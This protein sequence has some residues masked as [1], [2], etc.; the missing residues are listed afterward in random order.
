MPAITQLT[1]NFLGGVSKQIDEKKLQGQVTEC[2]NGYPDPT[3]GL[4]KR[5]GMK[6]ISVLKDVNGA[7]INKATLADASWF[8]IDRSEAGSY[9]GCIKNSNIYVWDENGTP[10]TI[11]N[12]AG[13]YL[14]DFDATTETAPSFHFRSIQDTTIITNK[15]VNTAMQSNAD[16][17]PKVKATIKLSA[18]TNSEYFVTI[19]G[20]SSVS[21]PAGTSS[22]TPPDG[23][24]F[25][26]MLTPTLPGTG[27]QAHTGTY[28]THPDEYLGDFIYELIS[29]Q[30]QAAATVPTTF[31]GK[32]YI[33]SHLNSLTIQRTDEAT[34]VVINSSTAPSGNFLDFDISVKGGTLNTDIEVYQDD[35]TSIDKLALNSF[36]GDVVRVLNTDKPEDDYY[37]KYVAYN[38][39]SGEGYWAETVSPSASP[40]VDASK[41]PHE[42]VNTGP[43]A[44]TFGPIDYTPRK[45]GDDITSPQPS[46]IGKKITSTFFYSDRF[47]VLSEDNVFLGVA[48]DRKNLFVKSALVQT[49]SDPI[50]LNV[51]S[52]KPVKLS[53]VLPSPQGLILFSV[54]Q[55]YQLYTTDSAALTPTTAVIKSLSNYEMAT[56]V[57][58][59]DVGTTPVFITKVPGY[60]KL[61]TLALR[62]IEQPPIVVDISKTVLEWIPDTVDGLTVSPPNSVV[63]LSDRSTSYFYVYKYYNNGESDLFQSWVKWKIP[64][65]IESA[66]IINDTLFI[67]SQHESEYTLESITLDEIPSGTV[68]S[69]TDNFS[70]NACLDMA[71]RPVSPDGGTTN[72]VVYDDTNDVTKIYVPYTPIAN[73]EAAMLLTVPTADKGTDAELDSDQGY[74]AVATERIEIGTGFRYFEV[75]GNFADYAD[76]IVVGYNYDFDVELPKFFVKLDQAKAVSDYTAT[77]TVSRVKFS[78]G[79]TGVIRFEIKAKGSNEWKEIQ[80][81]IDAGIYSGDTN[82]VTLEKVFTLPIHQ[83][84]TNFELKVTSNYPYPVSLVSMMWEGMYSPRFYRRS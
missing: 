1:P 31:T 55:Q 75:K 45:T 36:H 18:I 53:D 38:Q 8:F 56:D 83:R 77:L 66:E 69:T 82:P 64:G 39:T 7:V 27:S 68:V 22:F 28:A 48:N 34:G 37:L 21:S 16:F 30:Q 5:P 32:W 44:F 60:T 10:C 84:N 33:Q 70:G 24:S 41:M 26:R 51:S 65:T 76:G 62:D 11:T 79:R 50:D 6:H 47:G 9:I 59:K 13:T 54:Q 74:W 19:Q 58:P 43:L 12:S 80:N 72:P 40:G 17:D 42:L 23:T 63:I 52:V 4:L 57:A 35:V 25:N 71:T 2:V 49:A 14:T 15:A 61:F 3:F 81:T 20:V 78:I 73:K 29:E 46:F 67:V